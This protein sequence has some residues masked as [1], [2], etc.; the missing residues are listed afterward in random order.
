MSSVP[1][2]LVKGESAKLVDESV[3]LIQEYN[4]TL[5]LL[6]NSSESYPH[7]LSYGAWLLLAGA[8]SVFFSGVPLVLAYFEVIELFAAGSSGFFEFEI[9]TGLSTGIAKIGMGIAEMPLARA[10]KVNQ[11][12]FGFTGSALAMELGL[13]GA[14]L[15]SERGYRLG[16]YYGNLADIGVGLYSTTRSAY[17]LLASGKLD[18]EAASDFIQS[19]WDVSTKESYPTPTRTPTAHRSTFSSMRPL[20]IDDLLREAAPMPNQPRPNVSA[21][22][23][24]NTIERSL[25]ATPDHPIFGDLNVISSH[26]NQPPVEP[27]QIQPPMKPDP[28]PPIPASESSNNIPPSNAISSSKSNTATPP[29]VISSSKS[30]TNSQQNPPSPSPSRTNQQ[31]ESPNAENIQDAPTVFDSSG[32]QNVESPTS[33]NTNPEL[34]GQRSSNAPGQNEYGPNLPDYLGGTAQSQP[35]TEEVVQPPTETEN[36]EGAEDLYE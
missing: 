11:E 25:F 24:Q 16:V 13:W 15:N 26:S 19:T 32:A 34:T 14:M 22:H 30:N 27:P 6:H 2:Y 23:D 12:V 5:S 35:E 17:R 10:Q 36:T 1:S 20:H 21:P 31:S 7:G 8:G 29:S 4:E 18:A 33:F 9:L 3:K 28:I